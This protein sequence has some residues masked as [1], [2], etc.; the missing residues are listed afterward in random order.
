MEAIAYETHNAFPKK[1]HTDEFS[2]Q[3]FHSS[4]SMLVCDILHVHRDVSYIR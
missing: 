2:V 1:Y 3:S 4:E